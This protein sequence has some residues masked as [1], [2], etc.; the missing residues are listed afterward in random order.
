MRKLSLSLLLLVI[1]T[2]FVNSQTVINAKFRPLSY[3][4]LM[5]QAQAQAVDR[6]YRE[7][8][9]NEYLYEAYRALGK[10]DKSGFI[11]Y[12]NYALNTGFYTEKLYYDR[13]QVFQSF[14]DYKSAKKEYKKAKSKGYYQ[15]KAALEALKQ[16]KKQQKE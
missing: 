3:E 5:L 6:A 14:G 11:T 7:K 16:L 12:S 13:G 9:F 15:A 4:Q 1:T 2:T 8:M 10:G